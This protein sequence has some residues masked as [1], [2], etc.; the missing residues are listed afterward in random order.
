MSN[1]TALPQELE[2]VHAFTNTIDIEPGAEELGTPAQSRAWLVDQDLIEADDPVS[3]R[4]H[5]EAISL[6]GSLR[7]VLAAHNGAELSP[8]EISA[9]NDVVARYP[10]TVLFGPHAEPRIAST[11]SG[12]R[13]ALGEI[14]AGVVIAVSNGTWPRL[15]SCA[16]ESCQW[17]F[18]DHSKNRSKRW[19]SM[20]VCGNRTKTKAYR[21]RH[22]VPDSRT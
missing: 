18:Y 4:D 5:R 10:L 12:V 3:E 21:E 22:K 1:A 20:T 11:G 6:R 17:V 9:I 2:L 16:R 15:K 13:G 7:S 19:C 14:M 8:Q